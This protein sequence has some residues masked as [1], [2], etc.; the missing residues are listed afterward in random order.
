M[1]E[2]S[3][4]RLVSY[5]VAVLGPALT[6]S[7]RWALSAVLGDRAL[8]IAFFP[9]VLFAAYVGGFGPGW[10]ATLLSAFSGTYLLVEPPYSLAIVTVA[11][12]VALALFLLVGTVINLLG[13]WLHRS[14]YRTGAI[15]R[16]RADPVP[17]ATEDALRESEER[18]RGTFHNA[19][20]GIVPQPEHQIDGNGASCRLWVA[21]VS[22]S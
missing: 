15:E 19:A 4:A 6:L 22:T 10:L 8:F 16:R 1:H 14:R 3:H 17:H 5:G 7:V 18:F 21:I 9:A 11:D 12:A 13:E 20:V 2:R